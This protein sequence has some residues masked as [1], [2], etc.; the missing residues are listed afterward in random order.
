MP[1]ER[2]KQARQKTVGTKQTLKAVEKGQ[3]KLVY[4]AGDADPHLVNP[5]MKLC[6]EKAIPVVNVD[7]MEALGLACNIKVGS[8]S[9]A[10]VAE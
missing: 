1:L 9:A 3:V 6:E 5:L 4:I 10:I 8:A 2:L 7:S